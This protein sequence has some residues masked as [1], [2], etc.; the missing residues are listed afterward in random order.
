MEQDDQEF[1]PDPKKVSVVGGV[2]FNPWVNISAC[3][4]LTVALAWVS[5]WLFTTVY[6]DVT[7]ASPYP[8]Q[9][10]DAVGVMI[11]AVFLGIAAI[12]LAG[13]TIF[14]IR[15]WARRIRHTRAQRSDAQ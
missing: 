4:I 12:I 2:I 8:D 6:T 13:C 11:G 3:V 7:S 9:P 1:R 14:V 10:L 5:L 15:W